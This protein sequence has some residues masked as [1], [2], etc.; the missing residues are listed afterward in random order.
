MARR[1]KGIDDY[2]EDRRRDLE[3][4]VGGRERQPLTPQGDPV[5]IVK[6]TKYR[7]LERTLGVGP[8]KRNTERK[9]RA[10]RL[11]R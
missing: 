11:G 6:P 4:L 9:E 2:L 3:R 5:R 7:R 8:N 10:Q 1:R